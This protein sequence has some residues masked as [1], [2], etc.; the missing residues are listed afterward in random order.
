MSR[1]SRFGHA[2]TRRSWLARLRARLFSRL[3]RRGARLDSW[4]AR[5]GARFDVSPWVVTGCLFAALLVAMGAAPPTVK[6]MSVAEIEPGMRGYGLSVF[7]GTEPERFDI[8]VID[9]LENFRP[10]QDLVLIKT[11]HPLLEHTGSVAGMSGSPIYIQERLVGAYAYGWSFGKDPI[12]GV[13]P[14]A[15]MLKELDRPVRPLLGAPLPVAARRARSRAEVR[16]PAGAQHEP[17]D[18]FWALSRFAEAARPDHGAALRPAATPLL[19]GG[20]TAPVAALLR[21]KLLPLGL[22]VLEAA[23]GA[24]KRAPEA[25]PAGYVDG[26]SIAVTL[27][28]GDIQATGVGTVTHVDGKR[29]IAFGHPMID[30]GEAHLPTATSRVLHVMASERSSFKI[31]EALRP[32]GSLVHDRQSAIVIDTEATARTIPVR[33]KLRGLGAL[34]RD[35]W[36]VEVARHRLLTPALVL[37]ALSSALGAAVNDTTDMMY[38]AHGTVTLRGYGPQRVVDE[39]FAPLGVAQAS[40]LARLRIFDLIDLAFTNSFEPVEIER[41]AVELELRFGRDVTELMGAQLAESEI[42]PGKPARVVLSLRP[43]D[44]PIEQR[45]VEVPLPETLAGEHVEIE[46]LP[47]NLARL[48]QPVP[49]QLSDLLQIARA[50][51]PSTSLCVQV[52]RRG[53]GLSLG[54]H[55]IKNLPSSALDLLNTSRDTAR[56]PLFVTEQRTN[57]PMGSVMIGSAKLSL[58]VRKEAR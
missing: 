43:F 33:V 42:D 49:Q 41:V 7:R 39:G 54:S 28:R 19:V 51:L 36:Q 17:R 45:V 10:D 22:E 53:R 34:P 37:S 8:E 44:G 5:R 55:V 52:Q 6:L 26:G 13:T 3:A 58:E 40:A 48:E 30:A 16:S 27:V 25:S 18:A 14:I 31:A 23:G 35:T 15:N 2:R 50:G 32:L 11:P 21:E 4:L 29:V 46:I 47:G 57:L 24:R 20:M 38:R 56:S 9:V 1:R 12:A